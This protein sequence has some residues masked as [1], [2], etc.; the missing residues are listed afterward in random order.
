[1]TVVHLLVCLV[2][3]FVHFAVFLPVVAVEVF[4]LGFVLMVELLALLVVASMHLV[5]RMLRLLGLRLAALGG[6]L[7][8]CG[9]FL[10]LRLVLLTAL[11]FGFGAGLLARRMII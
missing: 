1:V 7:C 6:I 10:A 8:R 4:P 5:V 2:V 9:F 11:P 3:A